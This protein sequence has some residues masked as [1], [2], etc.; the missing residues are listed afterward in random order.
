MVVLFLLVH[1]LVCFPQVG[2]FSSPTG[3]MLDKGQTF[4]LDLDAAKGDKTRVMLP[5]PEIIE[6]S[7]VGHTLMV[8]DGKV[9]LKVIGKG[10]DF[11][12]CSV[13]VPG[14]ISNRKGVNT[15]DS[16]S[17][18]EFCERSSGHE[19]IFSKAIFLFHRF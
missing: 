3:E 11:L 2:E 14:K 13:E 6:A 4:R 1:K 9:R 5:H 15:P 16:V 10:K 12:D 17:V 19:C 18:K 8:D 7:E